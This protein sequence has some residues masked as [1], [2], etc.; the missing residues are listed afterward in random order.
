MAGIYPKKN[1]NIEFPCELEVEDN[2]L[3]ERDGWV[4]ARAVPTGFLRIK[5]EVLERMSAT[6]HRYIDGTGGGKEARNI[7]QMGFCADKVAETG[8]GEWWGEDYAWCRDYHGIQGQIWVWPNINFGHMG[9]KTWR[10]NFQ[11]YVDSGRQKL[12][13][14]RAADIGEKYAGDFTISNVI[15]PEFTR[16][17]SAA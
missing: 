8:F 3:I 6:A 16:R 2:A 9:T 4:K 15:E 10:A 17:D 11:P 7:F 13:E 14:K 1:D 5:R 12:E